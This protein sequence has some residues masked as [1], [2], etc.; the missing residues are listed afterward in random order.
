MRMMARKKRHIKKKET[1]KMKKRRVSIRRYKKRLRVESL[2]K[3]TKRKRFN[4]KLR[5]LV[6]RDYN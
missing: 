5:N 4:R 2:I 1:N 6:Y 3:I